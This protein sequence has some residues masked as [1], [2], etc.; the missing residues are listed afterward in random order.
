MR[1]IVLLYRILQIHE[2][3][4]IFISMAKHPQPAIVHEVEIPLVTNETST[5]L[6]LTPRGI[7][8]VMW[9]MMQLFHR[10]GQFTVLSHKYQ[11][12]HLQ[13]FLEISE[14]FI[15][16]GVSTD[17]VNLMLFLFSLLGEEKKLLNTEPKG[18]IKTWYD[19]DKKFLIRFFPCGKTGRLCSVILRFKHRLFKNLYQSWERFKDLL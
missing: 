17:F 9:N 4:A 6:N 12:V 13:N 18:S 19:L 16:K 10:S 1:K 3:Q 8:D 7:F 15:P 11:Q 2:E 5:I 14:T